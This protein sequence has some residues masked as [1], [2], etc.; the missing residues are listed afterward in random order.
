[1]AFVDSRCIGAFVDAWL[2]QLCGEKSNISNYGAAQREERTEAAIFAQSE[3]R[4]VWSKLNAETVFD[5]L[6]VVYSS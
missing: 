6:S 2:L 4:I 5:R 3:L 1:M